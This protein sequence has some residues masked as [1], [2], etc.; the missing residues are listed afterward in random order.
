[1]LYYLLVT[2]TVITLEKG[3]EHI[4]ILEQKLKMLFKAEI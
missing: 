1:M 4:Y 3:S 2:V